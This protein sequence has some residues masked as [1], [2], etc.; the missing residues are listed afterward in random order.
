MEG[1]VLAVSENYGGRIKLGDKWLGFAY[2]YKGHRPAKGEQVRVELNAKGY[3]SN[4]LVPTAPAAP[5]MQT[6]TTAPMVVTQV[7]SGLAT[8]A[9]RAHAIQ[10]ASRILTNPNAIDAGASLEDVIKIA[11]ELATKFAEWIEENPD[12]SNGTS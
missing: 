10:A 9:S 6:T 5:G 2:G 3:I 7:Q 12:G 1:T 11:L 8:K 4:V